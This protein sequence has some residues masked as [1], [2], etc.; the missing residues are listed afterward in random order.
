[1]HFISKATPINKID[2]KYH[3]KKPRRSKTCLTGSSSFIKIPLYYISILSMVRTIGWDEQ[4]IYVCKW[5]VGFHFTYPGH[6]TIGQTV[7][8]FKVNL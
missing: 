4:Y 2:D 1:M 5:I 8:F 6:G 7:C 3:K